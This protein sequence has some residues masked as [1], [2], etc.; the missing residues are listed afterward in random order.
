MRVDPLRTIPTS[1]LAGLMVIS[2][3]WQ[4]ALLSL[5]LDGNLPAKFTGDVFNIVATIFLA[6]VG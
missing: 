6:K 1:A 4:V 2:T 3:S 5:L